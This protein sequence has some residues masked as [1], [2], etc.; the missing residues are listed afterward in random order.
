M[1]RPSSNRDTVSFLSLL[2]TAALVTIATGGAVIGLGIRAGES[3]SGFRNAG[4]DILSRFGL[5]ASVTGLVFVGTL[6]H[7]IVSWL[8]GMLF[9]AAASRLHSLSRLVA[10]VLLVPIYVYVVPRLIPMLLRIGF[11][12]TFRD[13][14]LFPIAAAIAVALLSGAWVAK[15]D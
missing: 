10:C 9:A 1:N 11:G 4:I 3:L 13:A 6:H 15:R 12:V 14:D 2:S 5:T 8:W 7:L